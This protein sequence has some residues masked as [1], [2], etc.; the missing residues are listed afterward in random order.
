M[1][2]LILSTTF[3]LGFC[4]YGFA[5]NK[6]EIDQVQQTK[7]EKNVKSKTQKYNFSLFKFVKSPSAVK[8]EET[9]SL[10]QKKEPNKLPYQFKGETTD[11]R[12]VKPLSFFRLS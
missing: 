12:Y 6:I 3:I 11:N 8:K 5:T 1:K 9:D 7:T 4:V 10:K 2:K